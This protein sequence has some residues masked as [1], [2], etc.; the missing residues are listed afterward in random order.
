MSDKSESFSSIGYYIDA[1]DWW[2]TCHHY[3]GQ[4][5]ILVIDAGPNSLSISI[6]GRDATESAVKFARALLSNVQA[7]ADDIERHH[8]ASLPADPAE[9]AA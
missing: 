5:P 7:F 1:D 4:T 9:R 6:K 2:V 8:A 3:D